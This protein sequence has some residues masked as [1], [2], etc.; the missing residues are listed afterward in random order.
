MKTK[1]LTD[2]QAEERLLLAIKHRRYEDALLCIY[3]MGKSAEKS[4]REVL[5]TM[6]K[7]L[8][9]AGQVEWSMEDLELSQKIMFE[10]GLIEQ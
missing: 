3:Y 2:E 1:K 8:A 6:N 9:Q 5:D 10:Q 7:Y 4:N